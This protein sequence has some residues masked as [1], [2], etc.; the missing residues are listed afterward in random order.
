MFWFGCEVTERRMARRA[1]PN[2][3]SWLGAAFLDIRE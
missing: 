2:D 1:N 3:G